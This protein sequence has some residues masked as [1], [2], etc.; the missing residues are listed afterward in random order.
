[1]LSYL[2]RPRTMSTPTSQ[3]RYAPIAPADADMELDEPLGV[4]AS[5]HA[6][7][8][9]AAVAS[10]SGTTASPRT[11][12]SE[13]REQTTQVGSSPG[14]W[15]PLPRYLRFTKSTEASVLS[16]QAGPSIGEKQSIEQ[17]EDRTG[18]VGPSRRANPAAVAPVAP[19][20]TP[21]PA[22]LPLPI[23]TSAAP[24]ASVGPPAA[25]VVAIPNATPAAHSTAT[26]MAATST[27][28]EQMSVDSAPATMQALATTAPMAVQVQTPAAPLAA[29]AQAPA[30]A[31]PNQAQ[32]PAMPVQPPDAPQIHV[33]ATLPPYMPPNAAN[34]LAPPAA[35]F[36]IVYGLEQGIL[37]FVQNSTI[38]L[39][40]QRGGASA[41][42]YIAG[43]GMA[44][45]ITRRVQAIDAFFQAVFPGFPAP[46]IGPPR[47][48]KKNDRKFNFK[49]V[50]PYFVSGH[51][52]LINA[53]KS[54]T[55]WPTP[56]VTLFVTTMT[57][58]VTDFAIAIH[59]F[60]LDRSNASDLIVGGAVRDTI[61][62]DTS[63]RAFITNFN[64]NLPDVQPDQLMALITASVRVRSVSVVEKNTPKTVFNLYI[65]PPT[66]IPERFKAWIQELKEL[67][68]NC[69]RGAGSSRPSFYCDTCKGR[70]HLTTA[71]PFAAITGW[72]A[73]PA[74]VND[75]ATNPAAVN[76]SGGARGGHTNNRGRGG[77]SI[78]GR[79]G[80]AL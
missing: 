13:R 57:P 39:W 73:N 25:A 78:R 4:A 59:G 35:G 68:F 45:N 27:D 10:G 18:E 46:E 53:L 77:S 6:P 71:C 62:K 8:S 69:F 61:S 34:V 80:R 19:N 14:T 24:S 21:A 47:Y 42:V 30:N 26:P 43:D 63:I 52:D 36:P 33:P 29:S 2:S 17:V 12:R 38:D 67:N 79:R 41:I 37:S 32:A 3:N 76:A 15:K 74:F 44:T 20:S 51:I 49:P 9:F 11:L 31:L 65:R 55:C 28:N 60:P 72:P 64:D 23:A 40:N 58:E 50:I 48:F 7:P 22:Q 54:R 56:A 16:A 5:M 1:M 75:A 66:R 70:D